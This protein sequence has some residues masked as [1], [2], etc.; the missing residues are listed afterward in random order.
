MPSWVR[1]MP[2]GPLEAAA[3]REEHQMGRIPVWLLPCGLQSGISS[4]ETAKIL[5]LNSNQPM[6]LNYRQE[7]IA[8]IP[9]VSGSIRQVS[10]VHIVVSYRG[11]N[12]AQF[13]DP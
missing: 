6:N 7:A 5:C 9:V 4:S 8:T 12:Y 11:T 10:F 2:G 3:I 1:G 13:H